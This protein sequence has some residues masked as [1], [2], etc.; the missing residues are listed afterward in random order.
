[1]TGIE[2]TAD[3]V[4]ITVTDLDRS[5]EWYKQR[6]GFQEEVRFDRPDLRKRGTMMRLGEYGLELFQSYEDQDIP[7]NVDDFYT[8][9]D[10]VGVKH[11]CLRVNDLESARSHLNNSGDKC[12]DIVNGKTIRYFTVKDPD[13]MHIEIKQPYS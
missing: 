6:F 5:I 9:L 1:M 10:T 11:F 12:S 13:G 7:E 4:A 3:H 2:Y 8:H